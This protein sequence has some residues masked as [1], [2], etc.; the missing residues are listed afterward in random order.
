MENN[1]LMSYY[2]ISCNEENRLK[3]NQNNLVEFLTTMYFLTKHIKPKS[4]ILDCCAGG[5]IYTFPLATSGHIVTA[6]DLVAKHVEIIKEK[7]VNSQLAE[8]YQ[9]D[10]LDMSIF[11]DNSFDVVLCLGALYH[12][13]DVKERE[14]ALT[15]CIR[16]LKSEGI[17]FFS[18]INRNAIF[19]NKFKQNPDGIIEYFDILKT[20]KNGVFYGMA[21]GEVNNLVSKFDIEKITDAAIDGLRYPLYDEINT[22]SKDSFEMYMKYHFDTCEDPSIIGHSMHGLWIG[23]KK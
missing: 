6:G 14:K 1:E 4:T 12:L 13:Q 21:L 7:D 20:G 5:G 17:L 11:Q 3:Q 9:G 8:V 2:Q 18:Y 10:V 15:E 22:C 23:R 16:I 19:I